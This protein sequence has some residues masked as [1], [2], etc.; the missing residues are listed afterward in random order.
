MLEPF[1]MGGPSHINVYK[2]GPG[3]SLTHVQATPNDLPNGVSGLGA[4]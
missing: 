4:F 3:G 2:I 1:V